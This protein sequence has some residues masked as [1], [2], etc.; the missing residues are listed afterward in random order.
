MV[1]GPES[2]ETDHV[3]P[4]EWRRHFYDRTDAAS[5]SL[6]VIFGIIAA[7]AAG[8]AVLV[9]TSQSTHPSVGV[10]TVGGAMVA[11]GFAATM[12]G[13]SGVISSE[14]NRVT[15]KDGVTHIGARAALPL[16]V[17]LALLWPGVIA[18][19]I[20]MIAADRAGVIDFS[21]SRYFGSFLAYF[22]LTIIFSFW[23]LAFLPMGRRLEFS[24][25]GLAGQLGSHTFEIPWDSLADVSIY[26]G[27]SAL[28]PFGLGRRAE[29]ELTITEE[30]L[31]HEGANDVDEAPHPIGLLPFDVDE[32]TLVN[33]ILAARA[34]PEI[35]QLLGRAEGTILFDGPP[36]DTRRA[37]SRSQVWLPWEQR[38]QEALGNG[39]VAERSGEE[40]RPASN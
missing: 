29:I 3:A 26:R 4:L 30:A 2:H 23:A 13:V 38:I 40:P 8:G 19:A 15:A 25:H 1:T 21:T 36:L 33:V 20:G 32:D 7:A 24:P 27:P 9:A 22:A 35:R 10:M 31:L 17:A 11:A 16:N 6:A 37:M 39:A 34:H 28:R 12:I 14:K 5:L 18:V